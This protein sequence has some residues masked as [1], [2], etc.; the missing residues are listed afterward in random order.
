MAQIVV[1]YNEI[2]G[3]GVGISVKKLLKVEKSQKPEKFTKTIGSKEPSFLNFDTR[4]T[5]AK[6]IP[7]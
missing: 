3:G 1:K 5:I 2:N 6:M 7:S 4:L